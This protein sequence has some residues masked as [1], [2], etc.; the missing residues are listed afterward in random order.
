MKPRAFISALLS[1]LHSV[2][3]KHPHWLNPAGIQGAKAA[4]SVGQT[5]K[6]L[7]Q[8]GE[9]K[10]VRVNLGDPQK[11]AGSVTVLL[12]LPHQVGTK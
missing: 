11:I 5:G 3:C 12:K 10:R 8:R 4:F 6:L 7:G 9:Q 1:F 2:F